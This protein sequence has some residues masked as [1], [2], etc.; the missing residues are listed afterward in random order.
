MRIDIYF[1]ELY[2]IVMMK[3]KILIVDDELKIRI[4]LRDFLEMTGFEVMEACD[5]REAL[6][7]VKENKDSIDLVLLDLM[8]PFIDGFTV[9]REIKKLA[10]IPVII[11]TARSEDFDEAHSFE[12]GADDYVTKPI[13]PTALIARI[14]AL[15]KR[16]DK[17]MEKGDTVS[18]RYDFDGLV[19]DDCAHKVSL[20]E[21]EIQLSPK[22]YALLLLLV[23]NK[24]RVISREQLLNKVWGYEY[25]GG[26]RTVDTHINRLRIKLKHKSDNII[27]IRSYGYKFEI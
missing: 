8:L 14:N 13:K 11:L 4:L 3:R 18:G 6:S 9:C 22:E 21:E 25:Y 2:N 1:N 12:I 19:I 5:G 23:E 17:Q 24:S 16:S 7:I 15:F 27:T 20:D 10:A 26:L